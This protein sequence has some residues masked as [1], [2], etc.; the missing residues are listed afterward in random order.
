MTNYPYKILIDTNVWLDYFLCR[1]AQTHKATRDLV[2]AAIMG[3]AVLYTSPASLADVFFVLGQEAKGFLR[4]DGET[5]GKERAAAVRES[6]WASLRAIM[7]LS[8]IV[9]LAQAEALSAFTFRDLHD[10]FEDDLILAA[11]ARA[12]VDYLVTSD[13]RLRLHAPRAC[14]SVEDMLTVLLARSGA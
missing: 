11:A 9:P 14:L 1:D 8:L 5:V 4:D 10:D 6:S 13:K 2:V 3:D 7:E 12:D